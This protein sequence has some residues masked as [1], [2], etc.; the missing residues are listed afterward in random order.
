MVRLFAARR[1][2][3]ERARRLAET[4]A[5]L[6][7]CAVAGQSLTILIVAWLLAIPIHTVPLAFG[8]IVLALFALFSFWRLDD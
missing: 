2:T 8:V 4:L 6:R 1:D 7:L 3:V 5:W